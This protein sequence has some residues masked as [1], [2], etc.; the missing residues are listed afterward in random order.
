MS[1]VRSKF[2]WERKEG[3]DPLKGGDAVAQEVQEAAERP[4]VDTLVQC[5][6][7]RHV[8]QLRCP[9]VTKHPAEGCA[10]QPSMSMSWCT[11]ARQAKRSGM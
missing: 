6:A 7:R 11:L 8:K 5:K 2:S 10:I 1:Q 9:I 3:A 4:H